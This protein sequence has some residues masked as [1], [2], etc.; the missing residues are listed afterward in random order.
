MTLRHHRDSTTA[1]AER[2][3]DSGWRCLVSLVMDGQHI[4]RATR[5]WPTLLSQDE[6]SAR[7]LP[8]ELGWRSWYS[9][10]LTDSY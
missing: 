5:R 10:I 1:N 8:V 3:Y 6:M 7:H 9:A 2:G 4:D